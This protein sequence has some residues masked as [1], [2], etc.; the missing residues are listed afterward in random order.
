M[1]IF[2]YS[3]YFQ[4]ALKLAPGAA[5]HG[6]IGT[7]CA[8]NIGNIGNSRGDKRSLRLGQALTGNPEACNCLLPA[9]PRH[10]GAA[11]DRLRALATEGIRAVA[12]VEL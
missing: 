4:S 2:L 6:R 7:S 5:M 8:R 11:Q 3:C 1:N 10:K 12:G 9:V